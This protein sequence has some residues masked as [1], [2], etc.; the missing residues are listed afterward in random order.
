MDILSEFC[1]R[2]SEEV[3]S[4]KYYK[5]Y[6]KSYSDNP[7]KFNYDILDPETKEYKNLMTNLITTDGGKLAIK[8]RASID[9]MIKGYV[10]TQ[11]GK[12]WQIDQSTENPINEQSKGALRF[13]VD[14]AQTERH[15]RLLRVDN[16][17]DIK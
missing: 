17:M 8:T 1:S 10:L 3:L 6:P 7:I 11:D 14:T 2:K 5:F 13:F 15:L 16:P 12:M 9:F 4:G